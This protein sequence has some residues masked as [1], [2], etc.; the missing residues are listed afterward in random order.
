MLATQGAVKAS[1]ATLLA[2]PQ[3][4][5]THNDVSAL[6]LKLANQVWAF[7]AGHINYPGTQP[8]PAQRAQFKS[9]LVTTLSTLPH[10]PTT[11]L[12][13]IANL[14]DR[15]CTRT[16]QK[17]LI[18]SLTVYD[19]TSSS[20]SAQ[21]SLAEC[22][23]A[24]L[25]AVCTDLPATLALPDLNSLWF[26][27]PSA[28]SQPDTTLAALIQRLLSGG[29]DT[30]P[31]ASAAMLRQVLEHPAAAERQAAH[32]ASPV[33]VL[34]VGIQ[35]LRTHVGRKLASVVAFITDEADSASTGAV[36]YAPGHGISTMYW[37]GSGVSATRPRFKGC[38][39]R[40]CS[41]R[42]ALP[43]PCIWSS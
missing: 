32:P 1:V 41:R 27:T 26:I 11:T 37:P 31:A 34:R 35:D 5:V 8:G 40:P 18:D 2:V 20:L 16:T 42:P 43:T 9:A 10:S 38:K 17:L 14:L 25:R 33:K 23:L 36:L 39:A 7:H 22:L 30:Q 19:A 29:P 13:F 28:T 24:E 4:T 12:T 21:P 15:H 6:L 3:G